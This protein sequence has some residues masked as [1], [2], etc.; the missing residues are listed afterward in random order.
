MNYV[1]LS[2]EDRALLQAAVESADRLYLSGTDAHSARS[3][4]H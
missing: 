1:E 4:S 3:C 2:A